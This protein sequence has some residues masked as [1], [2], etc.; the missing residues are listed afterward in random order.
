MSAA[1]I[2]GLQLYASK[3]VRIVHDPFHVV[4][5]MNQMLDPARS[6]ATSRAERSSRASACSRAATSCCLLAAPSSWRGAADKQLRLEAL[7]TLNE[8]Q[9]KVYL[10]KEQLRQL[11]NQKDKAAAERML[12]SWLLEATDLGVQLPPLM[13]LANTSLLPFHRNVADTTSPS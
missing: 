11:W 1:Y 10:L 4:A 9:N 5:A 7:L 8:P 3:D 13:R 2:K 12:S 6:D